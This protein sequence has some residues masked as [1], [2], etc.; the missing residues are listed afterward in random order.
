MKQTLTK[1]KTLIT[2]EIRDS[3]LLAVPLAGAQLAQAATSFIDTVMMGLL[4]SQTLAAGGLGAITFTAL[5]I[6]G[7]GIVSA[8]SPLAAEAHGAAKLDLAGRVAR[9]GLW[10]AVAIAIPVSF[11]IWNAG[12]ILQWFG[13]EEENVRMAE[14]YLRAIV[15]G[16]LP[17]LMFAALKN[18]AAA[19][20]QPRPVILIMV[21]CT[22][23]NA[24][25][26]Y[27][28]MFGKFGLPAL[29][30][31][32]IGWASTISIWG[33]FI[34][35]VLYMLRRPLFNRYGV[36]RNLHRVERRIFWE[37]FQTGWPIGVLAAVETGLFTVTTFLMG[38]LGTIPLAA[39]QVALQTASITFM[40][41]LGIS[42]ATTV[43]VGQFSGRNDPAG[44]QLAGYVGIGMGALFMGLMAIALWTVPETIVSL[45]LDVQDPANARVVDLAKPLL[46]VA[47]VFQLFDGIQIIAAGALRGLK[48]TRIPMLIGI[49]SYWVLGLSSGYLLGLQ[50]GLGG[51]GLWCGLAIGL[52]A[53]AA[54]NTWR[55]QCLIA[56]SVRTQNC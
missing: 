42:F 29:G 5:L 39:H 18:F 36:F 17:G 30:L 8:V 53:A 54:I 2:A 38:Q 35:L 7:T 21:C 45:Y 32:G 41:P 43:R 4:G 22:V 1:T 20:S 37:L 12:P 19:L 27:V 24:A 52:A 47:A 40:V 56:P 6:I 23:F 33:M 31:A 49:L 50:F 44:A 51:V 46:G 11:L 26:N 14:T 15:W 16:Y 34:A 13:Q 55:F 3:L 9:Q 25:A 10:L 28:L 48:D